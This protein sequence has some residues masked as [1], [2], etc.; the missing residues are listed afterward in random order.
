MADARALADGYEIAPMRDREAVIALW[1]DEVGMPVEEAERRVDEV[2]LVA[3]AP[4]GSIAG[5]TS[6]FLRHER[7]LRAD[8]WNQ[9]VYVAAAH[10]QVNLMYFLAVETLALMEDRFVR[11]EDRRGIG[12]L[13]ESENPD[14]SRYWNQALWPWVQGTYLGRN[15]R[16]EPVYVRWFQGSTAP[17]RTED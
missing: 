8:L 11:G 7:G 4:D 6:V 15:G 10:R 13:Y 16:G 2:L 14:F 1:H 5:V 9:R 3:N 17:P 12:M